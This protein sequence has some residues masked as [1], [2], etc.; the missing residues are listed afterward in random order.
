MRLYQPF[1]YANGRRAEPAGWD[2]V[3]KTHAAEV[4]HDD[5]GGRGLAADRM[6]EGC[7]SR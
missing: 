7:Q 1:S 6:E 5:F 4:V 3:K 2:G